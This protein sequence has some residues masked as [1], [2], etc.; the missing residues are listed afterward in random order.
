M[1]QGALGLNL[2]LFGDQSNKMTNVVG[3]YIPE[4]VDGDAIRSR[5]LHDF[6]IEIGTSFG[7]LHGKIWRLG[8]MGYNARPDAVLKTLA[9]LEQCLLSEKHSLTPGAGVA[10][11]KSVYAS[12]AQ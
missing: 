2:K 10:A 11:A 5:M 1:A 12:A 6:N 4:N 9:C 3:V 8:T 7:P